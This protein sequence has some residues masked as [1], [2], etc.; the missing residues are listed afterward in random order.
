MINPPVTLCMCYVIHKCHIA[1]LA[2]TIK[3]RS[4]VIYIKFPFHRSP[5]AQQ[6]RTHKQ[7]QLKAYSI[8]FPHGCARE[9]FGDLAWAMCHVT[10]VSLAAA[11]SGTVWR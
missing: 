4:S 5:A 6:R 8:G 7:Q 11:T 3:V 9:F 2:C 1:A 10:L